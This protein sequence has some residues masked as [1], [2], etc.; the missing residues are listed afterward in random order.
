MVLV[1]PLFVYRKK[2]EPWMTQIKEYIL[3]AAFAGLFG[4]FSLYNYNNLPVID[5]LQWKVGNKMLSDNPMP[6]K[7]YLTYKNK[8][9]NETKEYLSNE[10]PWQDSVWMANWE[11]VSTREDNPNKSNLGSFSI[12]DS[13]GNDMTEHF[14]RNKDFQFIIAA[15]DL[16]KTNKEAF[17]NKIL[18][19][20]EKALAKNYSF[21]ILT[22]NDRNDINNFVKELKINENIEFYSSDDT[23]LKAM[24]RSNPGLVLLKNA[25]VLGKWHYRN[26]PDF[27]KIDFN[28]LEKKYLKT[29]L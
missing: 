16:K 21:I 8:Q 10:L 26:I 19:L 13:I 1:I 3:I 29:S 20:A 11:Y 2:Y 25:V 12:I 7:F 18:P 17:K 27:E 14:I 5:F 6:S 28:K 4:F 23:S 15:Y 24:I 9:T 22:S